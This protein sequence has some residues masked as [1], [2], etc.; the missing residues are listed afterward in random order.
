MN[1]GIGL[2]LTNY[3]RV[4]TVALDPDAAISELFRTG[5]P[6]VYYEGAWYDPSDLTTVWQDAA[7]TTPATAGDPVGRIDDKSGNGNHAT[8]STATARPTLQTSGGLYYLDFDGVDDYLQGPTHPFTFT[9]PVS[10]YTGFSPTSTKVYSTLFSAGATTSGASNQQKT[11]AFQYSSSASIPGVN[12]PSF[13]TDIWTPSG[14]Y[15]S[16]TSP[17]VTGTDYV[18]GFVIS[19]WSTHRSSGTTARINGGGQTISTYGPSDPTSLNAS[20]TYIGVFDPVALSTSFS[21]ANIYGMIV[22]D[23]TLTAGEI[24]DVEAYLAAKSGVTL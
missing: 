23:R 6:G 2:G 18:A 20:P 22:L 7:G 13:A 4:P 15:T 21:D 10:F 12:R 5:T 24:D 11:M 3:L 14:I 9:G 8:Q 19:N 17:L 16:T 1:L